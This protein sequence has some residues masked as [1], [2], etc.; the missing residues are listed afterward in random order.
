VDLD[1]RLVER[2]TPEDDRPEILRE[3]LVWRVSHSS[4]LSEIDLA[5]FFAEVVDG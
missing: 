2:W 5:G 4:E 1:S 3:R